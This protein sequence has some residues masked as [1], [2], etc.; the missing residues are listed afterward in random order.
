[1]LTDGKMGDSSYYVGVA[2]RD[3][4][5]GFRTGGSEYWELDD[6]SYVDRRYQMYLSKD[7]IRFRLYEDYEE[8]E[9]ITQLPYGLTIEPS[10]DGNKLLFSYNGKSVELQ[11]T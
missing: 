11:L 3:T 4:G 2:N 10:E 1:M 9:S 5:E 7:N 8:I 6:G